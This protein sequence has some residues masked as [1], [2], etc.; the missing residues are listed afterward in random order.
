MTSPTNSAL[1][2]VI[3][4]SLRWLTVIGEMAIGVDRVQKFDI[5]SCN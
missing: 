2:L 3:P 4:D 5:F 1:L